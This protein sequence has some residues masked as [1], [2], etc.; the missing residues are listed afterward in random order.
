MGAVNASGI[1]GSGS[2]KVA[3]VQNLSLG[4]LLI[5]RAKERA[6]FGYIWI[7]S[8]LLY[9]L[10]IL[11]NRGLASGTEISSILQVASLT[12][13]AGTGQTVVMILGGIDLSVAGVITLSNILAAIIMQGQA[14]NIPQAIIIILLLSIVIGLINGLIIV[15]FRVPPLIATF[16]TGTALGG[17]ALLYTHGAPSGT[18]PAAF[19]NFGTSRIG[20]INY[21]TIIWFVA[22][23]VMTWF[24]NS[25]TWG[26]RIF[27]YGSSPSAARVAGLS[28]LRINLL[29]YAIS[30]FFAGLTGLMIAAYIGSTSLGIGDN[31]LLSPIAAAA[32]GGVALTGGIG[33]VIGTAGGAIFLTVL[34]SLTTVLK[35]SSGVEFAIQGAVIVGAMAFYSLFRR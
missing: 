12:G 19:S 6:R 25:T 2:S 22:V 33:S 30:A 18:I 29:G 10:A 21:V 14:S 35:I 34:T 26:R 20:G 5:D 9:G 23:V 1:Q 32:L 31:Y 11:L 16:A 8:I 4:A 7:A 28:Y 17:A 27:A 3:K 15:V 13:L 24:L